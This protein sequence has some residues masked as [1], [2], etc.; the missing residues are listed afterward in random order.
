[1]KNYFLLALI[2]L[3]LV[4]PPAPQDTRKPTYPELFQAVWQTINENFYDPN[5]GGVDW[6]AI[7]QKYHRKR[8]KSGMTIL[9]SLW[10]TG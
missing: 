1:M 6:K 4:K 7:R 3:S 10:F 2:A 5:F 8:Q 9:S